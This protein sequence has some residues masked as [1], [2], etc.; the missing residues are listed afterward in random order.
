VVI[1]LREL[2]AA[3]VLIHTG[4]H[5]AQRLD[6]TEAMPSRELVGVHLRH[7]PI[8]SLD[9]FLGKTVVGWMAGLQVM[10]EMRNSGINCHKQANYDMIVRGV[11][12]EFNLSSLSYEFAQGSDPDWPQKVDIVPDIWDYERRYSDGQPMPWMQM[13]MKAWEQSLLEG[14]AR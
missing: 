14:R 1:R 10:P 8:R 5:F 6:S 13:V 7:C 2:D 3:Q 4:S 11:V 12:T 9:Q